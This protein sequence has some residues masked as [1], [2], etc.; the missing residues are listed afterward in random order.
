MLTIEKLV[1]EEN[2]RQNNHIELIAS[3]NFTSKRIRNLCGSVLT[4]KYAEGYPG[5]RYYGGCNVIDRVET[6]AIENAK[7]LFE[8]KFANVQPHS[9]SQANFSAYVALKNWIGIKD[10]KMK[11]L[12]MSLSNGGHLTHGSPVSFSAN[13]YEFSFFELNKD[14]RIDVKI[15]EKAIKAEKPDALLLGYSCYT[16]QI[17]FAP[18]AEICKKNKIKLIVDMA[19]FAGIV[20]AGLHD[21]PCK[22]ADL[23]TSTTHKTLRG[24]RGAII[25]C[26]DE[27]LAKKVNSAVFPYAQG[28]PLEHIIA[29]KALGFEEAA[30]PKF[31]QYM[32]EVLKNTVACAE[33]LR[34]LGATVV[35]PEN[36]LFML[37]TKKSFGLTGLDAQHIL[38]EYNITTN[39]NMLPDDDEKPNVTSGLRIGFPAMTTRGCNEQDAREIGQI[40]YDILKYRSN[41]GANEFEEGQKHLT[42]RVQRLTRKMKRVEKL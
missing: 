24:P 27:D 30:Q 10:R 25:L 6:L 29:G 32:E 31:K 11:I 26:N 17:A 14:G 1:K 9:G 15:V 2:E 22:Y 40:I 36:H 4:N 5:K 41:K 28:G 12:S 3:E 19:H 38:E 13:D 16:Y 7:R 37:N 42:A 35:L 34:S 21:N 8:C 18:F 33:K 23:V 20:A 39:K